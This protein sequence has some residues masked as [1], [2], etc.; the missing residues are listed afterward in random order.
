MDLDL[1][2]DTDDKLKLCFDIECRNGF[3]FKNDLNRTYGFRLHLARVYIMDKNRD[4][5]DYDEDQLFINTIREQTKID[6]IWTTDSVGRTYLST[7]V[8]HYNDIPLIINKCLDNGYGLVTCTSLEVGFKPGDIFSWD[9]FEKKRI[10]RLREMYNEWDT[11]QTNSSVTVSDPNTS[12]S[13]TDNCTWNRTMQYFTSRPCKLHWNWYSQEGKDLCTEIRTS[14]KN[15]NLGC[16]SE[17]SK[18]IPRFEWDWFNDICRKY[19]ILHYSKWINEYF[20]A[21]VSSNNK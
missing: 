13:T 8:S 7:H 9:T 20:N 10:D 15:C 11:I 16:K 3:G 5:Y 21:S 12:I 19:D 14:L 4:I 18:K 17:V 6:K 1:N 2:W